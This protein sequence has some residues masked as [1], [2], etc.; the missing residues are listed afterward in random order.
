MFG[1]TACVGQSNVVY[2]GANSNSLDVVF[3]DTNL[4]MSVKSNIV[5]DLRICLQELGKTAEVCL[6]DDE[7]TAGYLD[8]NAINPYY[9]EDIDFPRNIVSNGASGVALQI[10]KELSD[11]YTNAFAF[12]AANSNVVA[13]ANEF[14]KFISSTNFLH[15]PPNTLP[16]YILEQKWTTEEV[17]ARAPK[18]IPKVCSLRYAPPSLLGFRYYEHGPAASNLWVFIPSALPPSDDGEQ[19]WDCFPAIWHEGR[20]KFSFWG[21]FD[22]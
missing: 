9:P 3:V 11:A 20:W 4:S 5:A 10:P 18:E 16:D 2:Y 14:V 17:I 13:A 6:G 1:A 21:W 19:K 22:Y 15:I 12:A 7:D 8:I